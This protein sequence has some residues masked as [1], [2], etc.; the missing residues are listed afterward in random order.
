ECNCHNKAEDCY[1]NQ[2]IADQKR[3][4]DIHGQFIGG[5]VC[6]NCTQHT[7][8]INCEKC[9]DGYFR[10]HTVRFRKYHSNVLPIA[11][12]DFFFPST[13]A[14]AGTRPGQCQC[15]EGYVGEKCDRCAFGYRGY[16]QCL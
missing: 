9:A 6:L 10:P 12:S 1:Y 4:M 16:P 11:C 8:G 14:I 2:S 13:F 15:R 5:G 7:T 3:S